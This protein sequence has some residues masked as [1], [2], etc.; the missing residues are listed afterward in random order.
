MSSQ[1]GDTHR[2]SDVV[3]LCIQH[4]GNTAR[5]NSLPIIRVFQSRSTAAQIGL[6]PTLIVARSEHNG[7]AGVAYQTLGYA[8][9]RAAPPPLPVMHQ[10]R[11]ENLRSQ[12]TTVQSNA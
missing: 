1:C 7:A 3:V 6:L 4:S 2:S 5:S 12:E 10:L 8:H 11:L 9:R